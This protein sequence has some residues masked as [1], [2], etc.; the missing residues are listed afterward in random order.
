MLGGAH[1]G[2]TESQT[3]DARAQAATCQ[4]PEEKELWQRPNA[5]NSPQFPCAINNSPPKKYAVSPQFPYAI[6]ILYLMKY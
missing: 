1:Q 5:T 2:P 6:S 4:F 3:H